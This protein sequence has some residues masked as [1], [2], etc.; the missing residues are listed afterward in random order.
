MLTRPQSIL[1]PSANTSG[2]ASAAS[3]HI[4]FAKQL[5]HP[6][7][8]TRMS[9]IVPQQNLR[10]MAELDKE[11]EIRLANVHRRHRQAANRLTQWWGK[12]LEK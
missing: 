12:K 11:E 9:Q 2:A 3:S 1:I 5:D 4:S 7:S 8:A 10:T 6:Q